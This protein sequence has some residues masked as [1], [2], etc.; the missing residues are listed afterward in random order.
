VHIFRV[1]DVAAQGVGHFQMLRMSLR[2]ISRSS[3]SKSRRARNAVGEFDALG[4]VFAGA[5]G[6]AGV[7]Q[8][9]REQEQVEAV[10][11][12][13]QRGRGAARSPAWGGAGRGR[14]RW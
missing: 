14:C 12:G 13:Q 5:A 1:E 2:T 6:F 7:V 4:G 8:Q 11:F 9:Q 10:D 3:M